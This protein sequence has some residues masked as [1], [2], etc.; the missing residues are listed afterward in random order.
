MAKRFFPFLPLGALA[1]SD[2]EVE[3]LLREDLFRQAEEPPGDVLFVVDDSASMTEEQANLAANFASFVELLG[4]TTADYRIGVTTTDA[5]AAG[6]LRGEVL[7]PDTADVVAAF[8]AQ[9]AVGTAGSR[10]EQGIAMGVRALRPDVN[11]GF[12]REDAVAH[13]VF[14][15]DEDDHSPSELSSY[16]EAYTV[17]AIGE[18]VVAH[19]L[20]GD[21]PE[22]CLSGSSAA[23]AGTRYL[24]LAT[25]LGGLTESIC[26]EDYGVVLQGIG[27]AV[28]GWNPLFPLSELPAEQT[29]TVWVDEVEMPNREIDGWTWSVGDNAIVFTGRAIPRPGMTVRVT[30]Q[31]GT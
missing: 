24:S 2:Y 27:L 12:L 1:C 26:A 13:V 3:N 11:P 6:A 5:S 25:T 8:T 18:G 22:G 7:T 30:Y 4:D 20:V 14:V 28:S 19:A 31:R 17:A 29:I 16:V 21:E 9:V 10:D 23:D 15:S